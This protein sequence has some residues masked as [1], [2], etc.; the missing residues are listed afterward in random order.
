MHSRL[1]RTEHSNCACARVT[2]EPSNEP[3]IGVTYPP[4]PN[5]PPNG[6][7]DA[8]VERAAV[9]MWSKHEF[10]TGPPSAALLQQVSAASVLVSAHCCCA[11]L[12]RGLFGHADWTL[13]PYGWS[14]GIGGYFGGGGRGGGEGLGGES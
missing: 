8:G 14:G 6:P 13:T 10:G 9:Q 12:G 5:A 7:L 2:S 1:P 3:V 4:S 11:M